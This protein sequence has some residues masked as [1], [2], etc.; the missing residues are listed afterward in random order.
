MHA[1]AGGPAGVRTGLAESLLWEILQHLAALASR[2]EDAAIDLHSLPMT[3]ADRREL[4]ERLGRGDVEAMLNVAGTSEIW[5]TRYSGVWWL[6]HFGAD[7]RIATERIE[8]TAVPDMLV[9]HKA[10]ITAAAARLNDDLASRS[11]NPA[12]EHAEPI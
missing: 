8:I 9:T 6:R 7:N 1:D 10:D 2:G 4:E 11:L 3:Q 5:E 12:G